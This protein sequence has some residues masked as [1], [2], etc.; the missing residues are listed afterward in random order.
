MS[1]QPNAEAWLAVSP[2][3]VGGPVE[4]NFFVLQI[5]HAQKVQMFHCRDG[6]AQ[7]VTNF[8]VEQFLQF[9]DQVHDFAE[10]WTLNPGETDAANQR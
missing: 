4:F 10:R 5:G 2:D 3:A 6:V 8:T 9:A 1:E 7:T